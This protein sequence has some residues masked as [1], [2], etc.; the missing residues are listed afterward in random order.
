MV[1]IFPACASR[2]LLSR[3]KVSLCEKE[4]VKLLVGGTSVLIDTYKEFESGRP[5]F[6]SP[7]NPNNLNA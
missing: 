3:G 5:I 2:Y 1:I 7:F 6:N 4:R